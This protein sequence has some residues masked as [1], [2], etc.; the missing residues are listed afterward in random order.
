METKKNKINLKIESFN[1]NDYILLSYFE[2]IL[3]DDCYIFRTDSKY[4]NLIIKKKENINLDPKTCDIL[5]RVR[6]SI[7]ND[8]FEIVKPIRKNLIKNKK[9]I[10]NINNHIWYIIKTEKTE[11]NINQNEDKGEQEDYILNEN[12]IIQFC[13]K[14]FEVIKKYVN[15]NNKNNLEKEVNLNDDKYNISEINKKEGSIF[16]INLH[17]YE[18]NIN[19]EIMCFKCEKYKCS[20]RDKLLQICSCKYIHYGCFK[21]FLK[22]KMKS[23]KINNII[24]YEFKDF[25]CD[26]CFDSYPLKFKLKEK[27]YNFNN[28]IDLNISNNSDYIILESLDYESS[29]IIYVI[30]LKETIQIGRK[31][32]N[33]VSND[34]NIESEYI[35][36][37]HAVLKYNNKT[38]ELILRNQSKKYGTLILIKG[39]IKI[40]KKKINI[41][42]GRSDVIAQLLENK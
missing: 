28:L 5:F 37:N 30:P 40:K 25:F 8:S 32:I 26:K 24:T 6:K 17:F 10:N 21:E 33:E 38:G 20:K 2:L 4:I 23:Y 41:L 15:M 14:K 42:V 39:N 34:I 31:N 27:L 7:I 35:S 12:D 9:N 36:P 19:V 13:D 11:G 22:D 3:S 18:N 1:T 29:K 16:N